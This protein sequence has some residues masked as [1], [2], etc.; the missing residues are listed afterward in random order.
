MVLNLTA[1]TEL[2]SFLSLMILAYRWGQVFNERKSPVTRTLFYFA[3]TLSLYFFFDGFLILFFP[4]NSSLLKFSVIS[5]M[6]FQS[7]ACAFLAYLIIYIFIPKI[8]PIFGF[9]FIFVLGLIGTFLATLTPFSP[10]LRSMGLIKTIEWN[11]PL[12]ISLL[13]FFIFSI[14]FIPMSF[15]FLFYSQ[16]LAP[17]FIKMRS[18]GAALAFLLGLNAGFVNF[19]LNKWLKL[20][21]LSGDISLGF[22]S[23][24]L[25][26]LLFCFSFQEENYEKKEI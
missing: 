24:V 1:L 3:L 21:P 2:F 4:E 14:T 9:H 17:S 19:F 7:L 12:P 20:N 13:Q 11:V 8:D 18:L 5:G 6:F 16:S 26:L 15:I 23:L 10:S 22:F 25:F